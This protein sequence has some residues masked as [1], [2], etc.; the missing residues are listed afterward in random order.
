MYALNKFIFTGFSFW[1]G[2]VT[3]ACFS[4]SNGEMDPRVGSQQ[5]MKSKAGNHLTVPWVLRTSAMGDLMP[6]MQFCN[7]RG[8]MGRLESKLMSDFLWQSSG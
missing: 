6:V 5:R 2:W 1:W 3:L 8:Y 4:A 7:D